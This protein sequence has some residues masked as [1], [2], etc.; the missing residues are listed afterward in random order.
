MILAT[1]ST[2][3][4]ADVLLDAVQ[5]AYDRQIVD[6]GFS[7][8]WTLTS[9]DPMNPEVHIYL[10]GFNRLQG[11]RQELRHGHERSDRLSG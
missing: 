7:P 8:H 1:M 2:Q 10:R 11:C 3:A 9:D 5:T 6:F 4:R